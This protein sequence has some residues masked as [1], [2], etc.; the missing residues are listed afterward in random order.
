MRFGLGLAGDVLIET[1]DGGELFVVGSELWCLD[2]GANGL[3]Q[4]ALLQ[5]DV[6]ARDVTR[7]LPGLYPTALTPA[8]AVVVQFDRTAGKPGKQRCVAL[9][10]DL[11]SG[12]QIDAVDLP[13]VVEQSGDKPVIAAG[14]DV[15][16]VADA[17]NALV[18]LNVAD[19][20]ARLISISVPTIQHRPPAIPPA[21]V[22]LAELEHDA[23]QSIRE[24]LGDW[25]DSDGTQHPFISGVVFESISL[26]ST[27]PDTAIIATFRSSD[28]S[29][30]LFGTRWYLYDELGNVAESE[31]R[32]IDL[33]EK[34]EGGSGLPAVETCRP[35]TD[36]IVWID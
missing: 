9:I 30:V 22:D 26:G 20:T 16:F 1:Q 24:Q 36:G 32:G 33:M 34:V 35:D 14:P 7:S 29:S 4:A 28:R 13:T 31:Y 11:A 2:Y 10:V 27:F 23:L 21:G 5:V 6:A 3:R 17:G 8:E 12:R 25:S 15:W 19:R 18:G